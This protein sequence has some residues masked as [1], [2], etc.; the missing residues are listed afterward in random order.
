M[1]NMKKGCKIK[2]ADSL[3]EQYEKTESGYVA[4]VNVEKIVSLLRSFIY[5]QDN[6]VFFFLEVPSN[7]KDEKEIMQ[8]VLE[9]LHKDIYYM[10]NLTKDDASNLLEVAGELLANDGLCSF[11]FGSQKNNDEIGVGKYNVVTIFSQEHNSYDGLFDEFDIKKTE[12]LLTAW[13]TFS[14]ESPGHSERISINGKDVYSIIDDFKDRGLY[15][16]QQR[17]ED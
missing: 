16:A 1:L 14:K 6:L 12:K 5:M 15:F 13:D 7:R 2:N 10:D 8:G 11:G 4:N 3:Y 17:K 9:C